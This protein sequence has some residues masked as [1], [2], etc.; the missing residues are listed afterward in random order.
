[1]SATPVVTPA[2]LPG[3]RSGAVAA[4]PRVWMRALSFSALAL[5]GV[6]RWGRLMHDPP[7]WRLVGLAALA[8]ALAVGLPLARHLTARWPARTGT[9]ACGLIAAALLLAAFPV[10]GLRWHWVW[11]LQIAISVR[12]IGNGLGNLADVL[13]PYLGHVYS[14]QL[15]IMLG[16]AVL[17]LDAAAVLAFAPRRISDARRAT[18]AMPLIALAVVPSA[19]VRP[20]SAYLQGLVLFAL[21]VFFVWGERM[22]LQSGGAALSLLAVAGVAGAI[23]APAIDQGKP[24]FD[25]RNWT[26]VTS[27]EHLASFSWN[28]TYGPLHWP[29]NGNQVLTVRADA[30][31]YWKAENL[32]DFNGS[33]WVQG[34]PEL[35]PSAASGQLIS[36]PTPLPLPS[37]AAVKKYSERIRV[38]VQGMRTSELIGA[39]Q[40]TPLTRIPGGWHRLAGTGTIVA[41]RELGPGITYDARVYAPSPSDAQLRAASSRPHPW[42]ALRGYLTLSIPNGHGLSSTIQFP[43]FHGSLTSA[44]RSA[45]S[46]PGALA[47]VRSSPYRDAY[48]LAR[49][50]ASQS[51][52][53]LAFVHEVMAYLSTGNGFRYDQSPPRARYPLESFL[54]GS[55]H[56]YC[57]QFSGAMALL[58]RMGGVPVRVASGFTAGSLD[59]HT[60]TWE[61]ADTDA[62][63]WD[64]VWFPTYGWVK[65][66]PTPASAPARGGITGPVASGRAVP[67]LARGGAAAPRGVSGHSEVAAHAKHAHHHA[68]AGP[69]DW[70]LAGIA[71]AAL[72]LCALV[73]LAWVLTRP[74]G[75][76]EQLLAELELALER[77][78]RPLQPNVTLA[79]LEDRFR[80]TPAVAAYVRALRLSRYGGRV[81]VPDRAQR[82]ALRHEL[83]LGLGPLGRLRALRALPPRLRVVRHPAGT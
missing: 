58:L 53:E 24:W 46:G 77:T 16:A 7:G 61:V 3:A 6:Q 56:G 75:D 30:A 47:Y 37:A 51:T 72:A 38:T 68:A 66:D 13:V 52:S 83:G 20:A 35:L 70:A 41:N 32:D 44:Q 50:L 42:R 27:A 1:V 14:T 2:D 18:A 60:H 74:P 29:Q 4:Q 59:D 67:N 12:T 23:I 34:P 54:F 62:H 5:Y 49:R 9:V 8:I 31:Q 78:G 71:A 22:Q 69:S 17:L 57:Q 79:S 48:L 15:V 40:T 80:F 28:Q 64:E 43:R 65:F 21:L 25:Y 63:A 36:T 73:W 11:H 39:G 45:E 33:A 19:L 76:T 26:A 10:A 82:R 81:T 55:R